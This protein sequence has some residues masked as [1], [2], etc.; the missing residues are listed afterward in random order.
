MSDNQANVKNIYIDL[1]R[2]V[3]TEDLR[4]NVNQAMKE[5]KPLLK[6]YEDI[7]YVVQFIHYV[8]KEYSKKFNVKINENVI[9]WQ[10]EIISLN[11]LEPYI[12]DKQPIQ[13]L[14]RRLKGLITDS[15]AEGD[16]EPIND[17]QDLVNYLHQ[18]VEDISA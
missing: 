13:D 12:Q 15:F 14:R 3:E 5:H 8:L 6:L 16:Y 4:Q 7:K 9:N 10:T 11:M 17:F 1:Q 18:L 2:M